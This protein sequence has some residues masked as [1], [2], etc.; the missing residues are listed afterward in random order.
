MANE[1]ACDDGQLLVDDSATI[2]GG[3]VINELLIICEPANAMDAGT[4]A[5]LSC[6]GQRGAAAAPEVCNAAEALLSSVRASREGPSLVVSV[7][8]D[9]LSQELRA[10]QTTSCE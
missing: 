2:R 8:G 6:T 5:S 10:C 3:L 1:L 9:V 4:T 7:G